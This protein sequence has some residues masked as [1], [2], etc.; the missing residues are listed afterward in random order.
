MVD[1]QINEQGDIELF[2]GAPSLVYD[3]KYYVQYI[4]MMLKSDKGDIPFDI[5]GA[6]S[7]NTLLGIA[8]TDTT[9][10]AK[11]DEINSLL[12]SRISN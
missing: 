6:F 12:E 4:E 10:S 2:N 9:L 8:K 11:E 5:N 1:I 7:L 3:I